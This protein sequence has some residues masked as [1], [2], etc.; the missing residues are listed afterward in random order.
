MTNKADQSINVFDEGDVKSE[1]SKDTVMKTML[2]T[3]IRLMSVA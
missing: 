3:K 1:K 2:M